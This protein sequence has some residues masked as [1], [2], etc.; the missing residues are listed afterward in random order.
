VRRSLILTLVVGAVLTVGISAT[1][2]AP[3]YGEFCPFR[4]STA[5]ASSNCPPRLP[6]AF[7]LDGG[8]TPKALPKREM[9]P[10]ALR[11]SAK[12]ATEDGTQPSALRE[13]TIDF[14]KNGALN[15][16]GLPACGKSQLETRNAQAARQA[17]RKSIVGSGTADVEVASSKQ[18]IPLPLTLFNGGVRNGTTTLFIR[19]SIAVPTPAPIIAT[20]KLKRIHTGRYGLEAVAKI[21]PIA[22]GSGS[23]LDF[24]LE[25]KRLFTYKGTQESYAMARCPDGHLDADVESA[26]FKNEAK[27][28]GVARTTTIK[29]TVIRPCTPTG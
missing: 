24:S 4:Q 6:L 28:P 2:I 21:P 23:L 29:G 9:A 7:E 14:D 13:L 20:V 11:L 5:A 12:V 16:T 8:V 10:I 25:V 22:G 15:A 19:S 17:C 27:A 3:S 26:I 1:S 18:P